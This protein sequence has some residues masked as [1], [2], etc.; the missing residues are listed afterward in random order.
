[1][2]YNLPTSGLKKQLIACLISQIRP[3]SAPQQ[4]GSERAEKSHQN[5]AIVIRAHPAVSRQIMATR[6]GPFCNL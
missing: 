2:N 6:N 5:P 1:M 3:I 4:L